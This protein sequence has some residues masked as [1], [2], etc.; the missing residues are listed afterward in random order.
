MAEQIRLLM[1]CQWCLA[2]CLRF[3]CALFPVRAWGVRTGVHSQT[4][5]HEKGDMVNELHAAPHKNIRKAAWG[6]RR[7]L[8]RCS[9]AGG[10]RQATQALQSKRNSLRDDLLVDELP[11]NT[12]P[13]QKQG[14]TQGLPFN[15][16]IGSHP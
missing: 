3:L 16:K 6:G 15:H 2:A 8:T 4:Y 7:R 12:V 11:F 14:E 9:V 1:M 5:V 10:R 13:E